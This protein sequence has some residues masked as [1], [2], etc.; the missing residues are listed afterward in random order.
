MNSKSQY[1]IWTQK[2]HSAKKS[3]NDSA[4][5]GRVDP[6]TGLPDF[7]NKT[8]E[9]TANFGL[10]TV[11]ATTDQHYRVPGSS[12][13]EQPSHYHQI[14]NTS[15]CQDSNRCGCFLTFNGEGSRLMGGPEQSA[16]DFGT[17]PA[18]NNGVE[19]RQGTLASGQ[20]LNNFQADRESSNQYE[21]SA[22]QCPPD[23]P[24]NLNLSGDA[25]V[26]SYALLARGRQT[27]QPSELQAYGAP[28]RVSI[29]P[30]MQTLSGNQ[31]HVDDDEGSLRPMKVQSMGR[32]E[33]QS[34]SLSR[35]QSAVAAEEI[36]SEACNEVVRD[37]QQIEAEGS[38]HFVQQTRTNANAYDGQGQLI[39][40]RRQLSHD[41]GSTNTGSFDIN[42]PQQEPEQQ[43]QQQ[44]EQL[45][46]SNGDPTVQHQQTIVPTTVSLN[47]SVGQGNVGYFPQQFTSSA[48]TIDYNRSSLASGQSVFNGGHQL[49]VFKDIGANR[50]NNDTTAPT[51]DQQNS[52]G[53]FN[54]TTES[55]TGA[56][57]HENNSNSSFAILQER[58]N[59]ST[60]LSSGT[61]SQHHEQ[62]QQQQ[63][64]DSAAQ[65]SVPLVSRQRNYEST[66]YHGE[67]TAHLSNWNQTTFEH[68]A[69]IASRSYQQLGKRT[70]PI[71]S[72]TT[73]YT[74]QRETGSQH[75]ELL[76]YSH[77]S[78]RS[79]S[80]DYSYYQNRK[81]TNYATRFDLTLGNPQVSVN[82]PSYESAASRQPTVAQNYGASIHENNISLYNL[83]LAYDATLQAPEGPGG[84]TTNQQANTSLNAPQGGFPITY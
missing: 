63:Q 73:Y 22:Q 27:D 39:A 51:D 25:Y 31:R 72:S 79:N 45:L 24:Q 17:T 26:S 41:S 5:V 75:N 9:S 34:S 76:D 13:Y 82:E 83:N 33:Q 40:P 64:H 59:S 55:S 61:L 32:S 67:E 23:C 30:S 53:K 7:N 49:G 21:L 10:A 54:S 58:K 12:S 52:N 16:I 62:Q 77:S 3:K 57:N 43:Q 71:N 11:I 36:K 1:S 35:M 74:S 46:K 14:G 8:H 56:S 65:T 15:Y 18:W 68:H 4:F 60:S 20:K 78:G 84:F 44:Q 28:N 69:K 38:G 2:G 47:D 19:D 66:I 29:Q 48:D 70:P 42:C 81:A 6:T 37:R 80:M 50:R